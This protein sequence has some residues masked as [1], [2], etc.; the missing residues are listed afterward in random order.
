[1]LDYCFIMRHNINNPALQGK[2]KPYFLPKFHDYRRKQG[3][4]IRRGKPPL[5]L[6]TP[7]SIHQKPSR[8]K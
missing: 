7:L 8:V 2:K 1:M 4:P 6:Y 3:P 5:D